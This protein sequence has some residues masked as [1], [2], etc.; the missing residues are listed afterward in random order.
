MARKSLTR[1][2][3]MADADVI[4]K[5][6]DIAVAMMR[7]KNDFATRGVKDT[8]PAELPAARNAFAE[9][10][11]DEELGGLVT[12]AAEDKDTLRAQI[13]HAVSSI[14]NMAEIKYHDKGLY[15]TFGFDGFSNLSDNDAYRA[16]KRIVRVATRLL[17]ALESEG[18]TSDAITA[19]D[20]LNQAFDKSIDA[21]HEAV[22]NRDIS[23]QERVRLG[24]AL[25]AKMAEFASIGKSLFEHT[26]E[27]K[28]NDYVITDTPPP[29]AGPA[30]PTT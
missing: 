28:Y 19:L 6:D 14:R 22:E 12:A 29:P 1:D 26:D 8:R 18:L 9:F 4:Q 15:K 20:D 21:I 17:S 24:N 25:W 11:T 3:N 10:P 13:G 23:T 30:A 16:T 7:D 2:Y 5:A 27:A